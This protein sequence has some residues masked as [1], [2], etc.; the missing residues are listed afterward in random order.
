MVRSMRL[1]AKRQGLH[2]SDKGLYYQVQVRRGRDRK[3][4]VLPYRVGEQIP[5][6]TEEDIF[7]AL[8]LEYKKP[9]DR[10]VFDVDHLFPTTTTIEVDDED[11]QV[12]GEVTEEEEEDAEDDIIIERNDTESQPHALLRRHT[13]RNPLLRCLYEDDSD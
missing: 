5:C 10:N 8:G 13:S 1:Y 12:E 3:P 2:L 4:V 9:E 7:N 11:V 6:A